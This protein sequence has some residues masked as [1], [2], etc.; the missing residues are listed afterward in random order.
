MLKLDQEALG[1]C[2]NP[3]CRDVG[4]FPV[5]TIRGTWNS[6]DLKP[7]LQAYPNDSASPNRQIEIITKPPVLGEKPIIEKLVI[8]QAFNL[9]C[10]K[11]GQETALVKPGVYL[12]DND[13]HNTQ[14]LEGPIETHLAISQVKNLIHLLYSQ[15]ITKDDVIAE[16]EKVSPAIAEV[17]RSTAPSTDYTKWIALVISLLGLLNS[18]YTGNFKKDTKSD[19]S[20]E[21]INHL[22]EENRALIE[23]S[24]P[25]TRPL[26]TLQSAAH[27]ADRAAKSERKRLRNGLCSCGSGKPFLKCHGQRLPK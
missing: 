10:K 3:V 6:E 19:V 12:Y 15:S 1:I 21:L 7:S 11:C 27:R 26:V 5:L 24:T 14:L 23:K 8:K 4:S 25:P 20:Q 13:T 2:T 22:L 17:A 18:I 9:T 16:V